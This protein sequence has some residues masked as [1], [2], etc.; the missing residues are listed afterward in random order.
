M[1]EIC[2]LL[3]IAENGAV[4]TTALFY[5]FLLNKWICQKQTNWFCILSLLWQAIFPTII[6]DSNISLMYNVVD[7]RLFGK[8]T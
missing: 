4:M 1:F 8:Y 2:M 7:L 6:G 5:G 3:Y